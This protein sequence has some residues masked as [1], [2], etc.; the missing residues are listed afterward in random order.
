MLET[1]IAY[2]VIA[3]ICVGFYTRFYKKS[4]FELVAGLCFP[5]TKN[6]DVPLV[7]HQVTDMISKNQ[8]IEPNTYRFESNPKY[9]KAIESIE[10][11]IVERSPYAS[12]KGS[13]HHD[14]NHLQ[15]QNSPRS[16]EN[17]LSEGVMNSL[18]QKPL[19]E[20]SIYH[21]ENVFES[22]M[23]SK[24]SA[25]N[26]ESIQNM[27]ISNYSIAKIEE[28]VH[29]ENNENEDE[30][31][32]KENNE[33]IKKD[34][35][36]EKQINEE[37]EFQDQL[38]EDYKDHDINLSNDVR[39]MSKKN[40]AKIKQ[41]RELHEQVS[42]F[43]CRLSKIFDYEGLILLNLN[44][45]K[46]YLTCFHRRQKWDIKKLLVLYSMI[47]KHHSNMTRMLDL[48]KLRKKI[49]FVLKDS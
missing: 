8:M 14:D 17:N 35:T 34:Q 28:E 42:F 40:I 33:S 46:N 5:T 2:L 48:I 31:E 9:S 15:P 1:G 44:L 6:S 12:K 18:A 36:D 24:S 43:K 22:Q 29:R 21:M 11:M 32:K 26:R 30:D 16:F 27:R 20:S 37:S 45:T 7:R 25:R 23:H 41:L 4:L 39:R 10:D 19:K 38:I 3:I 47:S 13:M 49:N